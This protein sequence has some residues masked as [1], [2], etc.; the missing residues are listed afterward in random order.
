MHSVIVKG[1]PTVV[2]LC[3]LLPF[4]NDTPENVRGIVESCAEAGVKGILN[5]GMGLTLRE[6]SREYFY[7]QLD[8][9]F[10]GLKERYIRAYGNAYEIPSPRSRELND[11]FHSLC[12]QYGIW[13]DNRRIFQFMEEFPQQKDQLSLF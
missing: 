7:A 3:P 13:D 12:R 10:P 9:H 1:I 4:L 2:W 6:G 11:L 8:R 5:F